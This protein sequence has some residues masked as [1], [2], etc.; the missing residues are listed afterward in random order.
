MSRT[1]DTG[2]ASAAER[3][4]FAVP[5]IEAERRTD[6]SLI[7]RSSEPLAEHPLSVVHSF[8]AGSVAHP[9][10][11]L[12]AERVGEDW[13]RL[14]WGEA[15]AQADA[16][17]QGLLDRG[18]ADRPVMVLAG[19]SRM[20]L[21]V[22]L[23]ALTVGAALVPTGGASSLQSTSHVKL[24][25]MPA[26]VAPGLVVAEAGSFAGALADEGGGRTVLTGD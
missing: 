3:S 16:L 2:A 19:N 11:L 5:R 18:L 14:T 9:D 4:T 12:V 25:A 6:G 13:A 7:L 26:R 17:A 1:G 22:T 21:A 10:R 8:R 24:R 23:G 20:H 15:R